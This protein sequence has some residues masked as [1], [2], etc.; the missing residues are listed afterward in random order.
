MYVGCSERT[1]ARRRGAGAGAS[2][3]HGQLL[4]RPTPAG[5][6]LRSAWDRDAPTTGRARP[7]AGSHDTHTP[8]ILLI[9]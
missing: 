6:A 8:E 1:S 4:A 5:P 9:L 7:G 2:C 3:K